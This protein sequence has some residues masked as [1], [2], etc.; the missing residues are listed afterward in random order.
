MLPWRFVEPRQPGLPY[1]R[2]ISSIFKQ[3]LRYAD[4]AATCKHRLVWSR[5]LPCVILGFAGIAR[6]PRSHDFS[7]LD[8]PHRSLTFLRSRH[9]VDVDF[10]KIP[11]PAESVLD[12]RSYG[13]AKEFFLPRNRFVS[14]LLFFLSLSLSL[15][16][17]REIKINSIWA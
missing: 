12:W 1:T 11:A 13:S 4:C 16:L 15:S 9:F 2:P 8:A 17:G 5:D 6:P 3:P 14:F 10:P 7:T